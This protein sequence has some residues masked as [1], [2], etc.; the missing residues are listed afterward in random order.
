MGFSD[1][2][3]EGISGVFRAI[4]EHPF[5]VGMA[6]GTLDRERFREY[7]RQ[8]AIY[9]E[10]FSGALSATAAR[11]PSASERDFFERAA[12]ESVQFEREM[13]GA[14]LQRLGFLPEARGG[15]EPSPACAH[16]VDFLGRL[17]ASEPYEALLAGL[18]P[19][20]WIYWEVGRSIRA[21]STSSNPYRAWIDAYAGEEYGAVVR[22]LIGWVDLR[23]A[24]A[25]PAGRERMQRAF[26]SA[27]ELEFRFWNDAWHGRRG[28]PGG[29]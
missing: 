26:A 18:L 24:E 20:F 29:A 7:L 9:L 19:C 6:D 2:A 25:T 28:R 5:H 14:L 1:Q 15:D 12:Q 11:A 8:D 16:Y 27:A 23:A 3:W 10:A 13:Q 22:E 4:L 21:R 17:C